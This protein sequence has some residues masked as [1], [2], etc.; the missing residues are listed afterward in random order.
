MSDFRQ[1]CIENLARK[2]RNYAL[3][4]DHGHEDTIKASY[5]MSSRSG[6]A[7][8]GSDVAYVWETG[9]LFL[10]TREALEQ[11]KTVEL[12]PY[13]ASRLAE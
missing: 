11:N 5:R 3:F 12:A 1:L 4:R 9:E 8:G 13:T 6:A 2:E 7:R 10:A